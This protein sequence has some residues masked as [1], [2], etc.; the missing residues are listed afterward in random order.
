MLHLRQVDLHGGQALDP[1]HGKWNLSLDHFPCV[2]LQRH[3]LLSH[4][5]QHLLIAVDAAEG[6]DH[7]LVEIHV[8]RAI[9]QEFPVMPARQDIDTGIN[10][11]AM[12]ETLEA[13]L[14]VA[15]RNDRVLQFC[16]FEG[17][18]IETGLHYVG[19][20]DEA[21]GSGLWIGDLSPEKAGCLL[22]FHFAIFGQ[23]EGVT[24]AVFLQA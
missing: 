7:G 18:Q 21:A 19:K 10:A 8:G 20:G 23:E 5:E 24:A 9:F 4:G 16:Q 15:C 22:F 3:I 13:N 6:R 1:F 14:F 2:V 11:R 17:G 12:R